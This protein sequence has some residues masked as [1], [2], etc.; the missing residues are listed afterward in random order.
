MAKINEIYNIRDSPIPREFREIIERYLDIYE[1]TNFRSKTIENEIKKIYDDYL[2]LSKEAKYGKKAYIENQLQ[3]LEEYVNFMEKTVPCI[4]EIQEYTV[5]EWEKFRDNL[6]NFVT[7]AETEQAVNKDIGEE[8]ISQMQIILNKEK[9]KVKD[10]TKRIITEPRNNPSLTWIV[11]GKDIF[12][13]VDRYFNKMIKNFLACRRFE[14]EIMKILKNI[15]NDEDV[16]QEI[17]ILQENL[18]SFY[19]LKIMVSKK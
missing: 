3:R 8:L 17:E 10:I 2:E 5:K 18:D 14:E 7:I 4:R 12:S 6:V 1:N 11:S 9:G 19:K 16:I 13:I 15:N